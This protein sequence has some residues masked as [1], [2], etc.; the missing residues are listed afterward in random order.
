MGKQKT[1]E[2]YVAEL[3]IKNPN[4]EAIES[5]VGANTKILHRCL[6]DGYEW[7]VTPHN[8][9]KGRG[10]PRCSGHIKK[11]HESYVEEVKEVNSNIEVIGRYIDISTPIL[12][13]CKTHNVEW[14]ARPSNILRGH[15]CR[16]CRND[17]LAS[18]RSK[19]QEQYI[20]DLKEANPNIVVLGNYVN[21][22]IPILHK[23]LID[24]C[25]WY[26]KPNNIL[27]GKGCPKCNES[28]GERQVRQWLDAHNVA[29]ISQKMFDDCCD[30]K[31]L[32]FDFY[33]PNYNIAIEYQGEQHYRP[34]DYFGGEEKFKLQQRHDG[35]KNE[36]CE[37]NN[38]KLLCI[39]Y[40]EDVNEQL[41]NF[42]FI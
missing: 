6:I 18:A 33:L 31:P 40:Y 15:G 1:H 20:E 30:V 32:P 10:C 22:H 36:Y 13:L 9:L 7:Y 38:I 5:Y 16:K 8:I 29:Y 4:I 39:P 42:L 41:N 19:N 3:A 26:A 27:S 34:V 2:E 12:H 28:F 24:G 25:E 23:C 21:A 35:I 37:S 11:T 14:M 17:A